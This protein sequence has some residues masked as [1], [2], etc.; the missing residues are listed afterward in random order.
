MEPRPALITGT[1]RFCPNWYT[2]RV[3]NGAPAC[4]SIRWRRRRPPGYYA[5]SRFRRLRSNVQQNHFNKVY[6][7]KA[8]PGQ[9]PKSEYRNPKQTETLKSKV[10][11]PEIRNALV[12]NFGLLVLVIWICFEFRNSNFEFFLRIVASLRETRLSDP[13]LIRKIQISLTRFS[14]ARFSLG[15]RCR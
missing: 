4:S 2:S 3:S 15:W 9:N 14:A 13:F 10:R 11:I 12:W 1:S 6:R 7:A 5:K 8:P